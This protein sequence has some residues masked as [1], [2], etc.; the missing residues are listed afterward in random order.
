MIEDKLVSMDNELVY[1]FCSYEDAVLY[2]DRHLLNQKVDTILTYYIS[3]I[4]RR[5][6][7]LE[8]INEVLRFDILED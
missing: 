4:Q 3:N 2:L 7:S 8:G 1:E 5:L 6:N